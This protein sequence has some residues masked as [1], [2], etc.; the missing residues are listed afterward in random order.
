MFKDVIVVDAGR[1]AFD[2]AVEL[3]CVIADSVTLGDAVS[4]KVSL[5]AV[6][7]GVASLSSRLLS[8]WGSGTEVCAATN[9]PCARQASRANTSKNRMANLDR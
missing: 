7:L 4:L 1:V 9:K 6:V 8:S 5:A 3:L 2:D